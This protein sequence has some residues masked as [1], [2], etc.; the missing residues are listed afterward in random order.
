M[1]RNSLV[2]Y[3]KALRLPIDN[4]RRLAA[5]RSAS[6]RLQRSS[7][8]R[9]VGKKEAA[10]LG[11]DRRDREP[12]LKLG[13]APWLWAG[14]SNWQVRLEIEGVVS[15]S[16]TAADQLEASLRTV[17]KYGQVLTIY[18]DGSVGEDL[19]SSGSAAVVTTGLPEACEV[20]EAV[21]ASSKGFTSSFE[22]E[23]RAISLAVE[24]LQR[25]SAAGEREG[26]GAGVWDRGVGRR[27][28]SCARLLRQQISAVGTL[29]GE[30]L[31][32]GASL[33]PS[34]TA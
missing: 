12:L 4:P 6:H 21:H 3:E 11:L 30:A 5:E 25:R 17:R 16:S 24:W 34:G 31:P 13:W 28:I 29:G 9:K 1:R 26:G 32:E 23:Q 19:Q 20:M 27:R 15:K 8:W 2:A 7:S 18:T 14:G 22:A 33:A 10:E